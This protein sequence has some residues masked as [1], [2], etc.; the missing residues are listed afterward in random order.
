MFQV[1]EWH[2]IYI[3][4]CVCVKMSLLLYFWTIFSLPSPEND[5]FRI[6]AVLFSVVGLIL[7]DFFYLA[8]VIHYALE[9]QLILFLMKATADRIRSQCW[10]VDLAIKVLYAYVHIYIHI[11]TYLHICILEYI[12]SNFVL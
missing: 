1:R 11:C 10:S 7:T 9:C 3:C 6:T 2:G 8:A 5:A 4:V 12:S